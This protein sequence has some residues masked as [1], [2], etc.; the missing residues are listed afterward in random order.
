[1]S[2]VLFTERTS[3]G[4]LEYVRTKNSSVHLLN[5]AYACATIQIVP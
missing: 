3:G 2:A 4:P 1:M 5:L